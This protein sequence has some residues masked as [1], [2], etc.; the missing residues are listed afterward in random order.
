[1][2]DKK[3]V[4]IDV[5]ISYGDSIDLAREVLQKIADEDERVL[6]EE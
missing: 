6:E 3:R 2:E 1:M 5:G 4:D